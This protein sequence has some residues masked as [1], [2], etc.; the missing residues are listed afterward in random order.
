[1]AALSI[2]GGPFTKKS[3]QFATFRVGSV[4]F[5]HNDTGETT[6]VQPGFFN[7]GVD[8][9]SN[10]EFKNTAVTFNSAKVVPEASV[11]VLLAA[12][13]GFIA[14]RRRQAARR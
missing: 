7:V 5:E 2:Q 11:A 6:V 8:G 9:M 3:S 1:M 12:G 10:N 13:I 14:L 4:V